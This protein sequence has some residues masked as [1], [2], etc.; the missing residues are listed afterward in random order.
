MSFLRP[1]LT[2]LLIWLLAFAAPAQA[3]QNMLLLDAVLS[4]NAAKTGLIRDQVVDHN[5]DYGET[6]TEQGTVYNPFRWNGEQL[7]TESGLYY[8]RNRYYQPS[9]GRFMQRD[10]IGYEGG[11]NLYAYCGGDPINASDPSG[12]DPVVFGRTPEAAGRFPLGSQSAFGQDISEP[13][14]DISS[15]QYQS[16]LNM[17]GL[18]F[19]ITHG[20]VGSESNPDE[21]GLIFSDRPVQAIELLRW[22]KENFGNNPVPAKI[23]IGSGCLVGSNTRWATALGFNQMVEGHAFVGWTVSVTAQVEQI[24]MS[25]YLGHL[26]DGK[27]VQEAKDATAKHF[28]DAGNYLVGNTVKNS[29]KIYGDPNTRWEPSSPPGW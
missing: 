19:T 5:G 28:L 23:V 10:P 14:T 25:T 22:R 11:L 21:S 26:A 1:G 16:G 18:L 17:N 9:T 3:V 13:W 29:L 2:W 15:T 6:L 12:L 27:S 7:D 24:A 4:A 20:N 8:L